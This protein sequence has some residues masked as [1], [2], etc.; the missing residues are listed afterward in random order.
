MERTRTV[1]ILKKKKKNNQRL[2]KAAVYCFLLLIVIIIGTVLWMARDSQPVGQEP[3]GPDNSGVSGAIQPSPEPSPT[4]SSTPEPSEEPPEKQENEDSD[5]AE[6]QGSEQ[7]EGNGEE[8][9]VAEGDAS[10]TI[11][12]VGDVLLGSTV[13]NLLSQHGY[14][15]P[16]QDVQ[17][18][19][20]ASDFT[21]AN[22]ETPITTRGTPEEDRSFVYRSSP[23]VLPA[24]KEAGFD[25]VALANNHM[26]DYGVVGLTDT[27]D[28]LDEIGIHRVGAGRDVEEAFRPF[29]WESDGMSIAFLN[30]TRVVPSG[31]WKAGHEFPE[32][33]ADT[34]NHNPPVEAIAKAKAE[35]DLVI[36]LAHW[37][38]ERNDEFNEIQQDLAR[39]YIDAGADLIVGS[40]PHVLQGF[41]QYQ[42]KWIAYSLGNFIFTTRADA[43]KTLDSAILEA[44]C[45]L[46]GCDLRMI[47]IFT[48]WA[49]P[50]V[51]D[52]AQGQQLFRRITDVSAGAKILEDGTIVT[53]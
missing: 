20:Q 34:Y 47:P 37:G 41:E 19:L 5:P 40:H 38:E 44:T 31:D 27:L 18:L 49:K 2:L 9:A 14:H 4:P 36:V 7:T 11:S 50:V 25:L 16:Y 46:D 1:R 24:F 29:I 53:D 23:E 35:A 21:V 12:F 43:P 8:G 32:G 26:M 6:E 15:Y 45:S 33:L 17:S 42:G 30:F 39:R 13:E 3:G 48:E 22:L 28:Y 52:D 10:V 51:M